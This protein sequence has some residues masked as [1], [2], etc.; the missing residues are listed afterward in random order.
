MPVALVLW[1]KL[2]VSEVLRVVVC[3]RLCDTDGVSV[4]L[5]VLLALDVTVVDAVID[6]VAVCVRLAVSD[7]VEL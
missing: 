3:D 5:E 4:L 6:K 7:C 1:D 2:G